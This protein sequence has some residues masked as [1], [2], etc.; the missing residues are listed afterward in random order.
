MKLICVAYLLKGCLVRILTKQIDTKKC[1]KFDILLQIVFFFFFFLNFWEEIKQF[2]FLHRFWD[3]DILS[4]PENLI[5]MF[6]SCEPLIELHL[7]SV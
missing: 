6:A 5:S 7:T 4:F 3:R 2:I 1:L